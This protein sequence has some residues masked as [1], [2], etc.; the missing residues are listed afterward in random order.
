MKSFFELI[1]GVLTFI[2]NV[3]MFPFYMLFE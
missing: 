2:M 3:L 1:I